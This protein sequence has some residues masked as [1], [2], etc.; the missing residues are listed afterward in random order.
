MSVLAALSDQEILLL[1]GHGRLRV[2]ALDPLKDFQAAAMTDLLRHLVME[3]ASKR[4]LPTNSRFAIR[5]AIDQIQQHLEP[6]K[7]L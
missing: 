2:E 1:V 3:E 5:R 6:E 4:G 7:K